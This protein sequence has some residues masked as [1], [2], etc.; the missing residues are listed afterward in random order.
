MPAKRASTASTS[1]EN[2]FRCC[3]RPLCTTTASGSDYRA[4]DPLFAGSSPVALANSQGSQVSDLRPLAFSEDRNSKLRSGTS[5]PPRRQ[6]PCCGSAREQLPARAAGQRRVSQIAGRSVHR[7][8]APAGRTGN[9]SPHAMLTGHGAD[10][11]DRA[12]QPGSITARHTSKT[13]AS[14][15]IRRAMRP[16]S[17]ESS[18]P[19]RP[20]PRRRWASRPGS[21]S[22]I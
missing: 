10:T 14:L 16:V 8:S 15:A 5:W 19:I 17:H 6:G 21:G 3:R 4:V 2:K 20:Q 7:W 18:P 1:Q 13:A 12:P 22:G 11:T 9:A